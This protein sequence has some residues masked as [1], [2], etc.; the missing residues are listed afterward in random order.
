MLFF[1]K[2]IEHESIVEA[3]KKNASLTELEYYALELKAWKHSPERME[4]IDGDRYYSGDHDILQRVRTA[5]GNDGDLV[6]VPNLPNNRIIDNQYAKHVDQKKN[7]LF[8]QPISFDCENK[9]YADKLSKVLGKKFMR[10]LKNAGCESLNGG[11]SWL[12]P[13]YDKNGDLAFRVFPGYEIK[14]FWNDS[15][16]TDLDMALRLYPVEVYIGTT[17]KVIE[18]CD[19]FKLEGVT[20]YIYDGG[21]LLED[22]TA[23]HTGSD[24]YITVTDNKGQVKQFNWE[25]IPLIPIKCNAKEIPLIRR[26]RQLQDAINTIMSDFVNNMQEDIRNT[27]LVL[28]NY[29]GT[30]LGEFR[31]NL[32]TY[33]AIKVRSVEGQQGGVDTLTIEVNADNYKTVLECLKKALIENMRSYDAKDDRMSNNP[34]QMNIQSMYA[35]I[36]LDANDMETELQ[37]AFEDILWFVNTHLA[38]TGDGNFQNEDVNVIFNRDILINESEAIDNCQKSVGIIS[39]ETI[40]GM[41]PWVDDPAKELDRLDEEQAEANASDP[42]RTAFETGQSNTDPLLDTTGGDPVNAEE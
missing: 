1:R 4:Q 18:K 30:D 28:K 11:I 39:N 10:S 34:N 36:D 37:A 32:M 21:R 16:H 14:P 25:R 40:V 12:Y 29:D 6:P 15:A 7:Y 38:N 42:Y 41:H 3:R 13:Y 35:D 26:A 20:T 23:E 33:G 2:P 31:K 27:I 9:T 17:K 22:P 24:S 8:S 5:I 19:I